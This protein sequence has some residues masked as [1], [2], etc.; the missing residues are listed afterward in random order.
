MS[1]ATKGD[2][3]RWPS[4]S[5]GFKTFAAAYGG[6][7]ISKTKADTVI[8]AQGDPADCLYY[9]QDGLVRIKVVS[10]HGKTAIM[11]TLGQDAVFGETCLLGESSRVAT[12]VC[13]SDCS[14]VRMTRADALRALHDNP[15]FGE[16]ILTRVLRRVTRLRSRLVSH[17]FEGSEQRLARI[18]LTLANHGKGIRDAATT[19]V[20][21][22]QEDLAQMVGTTR[23]RISYFMN[24]FSNLG[25]IDYNGHIA[26][27]R[28]LSNVLAAD[29][30]K[31]EDVVDGV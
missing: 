7:T 26:V 16:F 28:S 4:G 30:A 15:G 8:Y 13:L 14:L 29:F 12:A 22:D 21:L 17:L 27:H 19:I 18:L 2:A 25:Y 24:K 6:T 31:Q 20:G 3:A 9:I 23:A 11:A 5:D 1:F 10:S